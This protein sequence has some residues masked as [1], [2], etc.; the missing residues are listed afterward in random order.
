MPKFLLARHCEAESGPQMDVTRGLTKSGEKQ[1]PLMAD[2]LQAM[3]CNVGLILHSDMKRGRDTAEGIAKLLDVD[4]AQ[5]PAV[6][7][8]VDADEKL[9]EDAPEKAWKV[10]QRYAKRL[11]D[12]EL[13][14]VISHGPLINALAAMLLE[15]GEGD[16]FHFSH[17]SIAKFD[18]EEPGAGSGYPY[19]GRGENV[20][21]LHWLASP[22]LMERSI[23]YE[24]DLTEAAMALVDAALALGEDIGLREDRDYQAAFDELFGCEKRSFNRPLDELLKMRYGEA[25]S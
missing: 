8:S 7:P 18:T 3:E 15:S 11:P 24:P 1:I 5:D 14:L 19:A 12:D 22:K 17:A 23:E 20:A 16:K 6:G 21:Y 4:S 2:F 9:I 13:L 10:I 25:K